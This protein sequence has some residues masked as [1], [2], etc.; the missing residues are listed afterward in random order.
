MVSDSYSILN[1]LFYSFKNLKIIK[2][3]FLFFALFLFSCSKKASFS[4]QSPL[5]WVNSVPSNTEQ[6]IRFTHWDLLR[7]Q[8]DIN[9]DNY[10]NIDFWKNYGSDFNACPFS[11]GRLSQLLVAYHENQFLDQGKAQL[12]ISLLDIQWELS[13]NQEAL[14]LKLASS[15]DFKSLDSFLYNNNFSEQ[16]TDGIAYY[17]LSEELLNDYEP[18]SSTNFSKRILR[19]ISAIYIDRKEKILVLGNSPAEILPAIKVYQTKTVNKN[20]DILDW[21]LLDAT[22]KDNFTL[23][24]SNRKVKLKS[25]WTPNINMD[26]LCKKQFD[27]SYK[28]IKN[29]HPISLSVIGVNGLTETTQ[30]M[31]VYNRPEQ[32]QQDQQLREHLVLNSN[33]F[34]STKP[35]LWN[36]WHLT[37]IEY[38]QS[39]NCL[40][41]KFSSPQKGCMETLM[42]MRDF[43]FL[44]ET[45]S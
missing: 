9:K 35:V 22:F 38:K 28:E 27:L 45:S 1:A 40:I 23:L 30:I 18:A 29:L 33:S 26:T 8:A 36:G 25:Y 24:V 17:H 4:Y 41:Y 43:P 2:Y 15:I 10:L 21:K 32:A 20:F 34:M 13:I 14:I 11:T 42:R 44:I 12:G 19:R 6:L 39:E 7:Q 31:T 16:E 5:S 37:Y 3:L